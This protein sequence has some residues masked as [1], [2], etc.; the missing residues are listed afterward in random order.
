MNLSHFFEHWQI[1]ENPFR[2]EEARHDAVFAKV[3]IAQEGR[4]PS[5]T[6]SDFEKILGDPARPSTSIV[7]G[8]KGSGKTAIRLQLSDH[9]RAHNREHPNRRVMVIAY[10]DLNGQLDWFRES[11]LGERSASKKRR[12]E[13]LDEVELLRKI[14]LVDHIDGILSVGVTNLVGGLLGGGSGADGEDGQ[15]SGEE[16]RR[17][18][19]SDRATRL[20]LM[21]L[22]ALYDR[23]D[24][25]EDR[26]RRLRR[27]L[28]VMPESR[29]A[30]VGL[31]AFLGWVVPAAVM[32]AFF[33]SGGRSAA[34]FTI[35]W[36]IA[37]VL[38]LSLWLYGLVMRG[39][40]SK[41]MSRRLAGRLRRSMRT[42]RPGQQALEAQARLLDRL[43][44]SHRS[45]GVLPLSNSDEQRY[46]LLERFKGV[47]RHLGFAHI[48]VIIDRVDEPTMVSG[49]AQRMQAVIWP[50]LNSKFLQQEGLAV[51]MLLPIE[52][53]YAL[54]KESSAFF[55]EARLDKQSLVERLSWTGATLYDLCDARLQA[56]RPDS[57]EP[58]SLID[59]FDEDVTTRDLVDALD[60]MHQPRDAFKFV[61]RCL[62]EHCS[63]VTREQGQWRIPRHVLEAMKKQEAERVQQLYRGIRPA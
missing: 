56:C 43:P 24:G 5:A 53:R 10:D 9:F 41:Y 2:G 18:R 19:K 4:G 8:E 7:F 29:R 60:Q 22:Q 48:V 32:G 25:A 14:R 40:W 59:L 3:G 38:S 62:S 12:D 37:L 34:H 20:D 54:F 6:H 39:V 27:G 46:A 13:D 30:L 21:L 16:L 28:R 61:Y 33:W 1:S 26:A 49:D 58:I 42:A 11:A 17:V 31:L 45:G 15:V 51:K 57:I 52:L 50:M 36:Q 44:R 47:I 35:L 23:D 63:N 55:Q